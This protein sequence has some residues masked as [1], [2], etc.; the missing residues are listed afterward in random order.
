MLKPDNNI[1]KSIYKRRNILVLLIFDQLYLKF[2][3]TQKKKYTFDM[4]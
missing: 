3:L 1:V 2:S 4:V